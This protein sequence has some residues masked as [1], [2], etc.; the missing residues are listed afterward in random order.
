MLKKFILE[1]ILVMYTEIF[2]K[3]RMYQLNATKLRNP[4]GI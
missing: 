3:L 1:Y 2:I 4:T